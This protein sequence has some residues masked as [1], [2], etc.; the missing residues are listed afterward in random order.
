MLPY[1]KRNVLM[2]LLLILIIS[3]FA[4]NLKESKK[5]LPFLQTK[6]EIKNQIVTLPSIKIKHKRYIPKS[7]QELNKIYKKDYEIV[8]VTQKRKVKVAILD[9]LFTRK[10]KMN[11]VHIIK[12][13]NDLTESEEQLHG[14]HVGGIILATNPNVELFAYS[15]F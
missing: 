2:K 7:I 1:T 13:N 9:G 14:T 3:L 10:E 6:I 8:S 11:Y 12:N 5:I 4:L 15:I